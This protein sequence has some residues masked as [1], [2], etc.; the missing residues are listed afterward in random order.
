LI[1]LGF[2]LIVNQFVF[3][4]A[5][6]QDGQQSRNVARPNL[7]GWHLTGGREFLYFELV[8][9]GL[10]LLLVRNLRS[11]ALGRILGAMRDSE[12]GAVSVGVNLRRYKLLVFGAAAFIAAIGGALLAMQQG[13]VNFA[14]DGPYSPLSGLYWF[15]AVVVFGLSY[16]YSAI[17]A[18]ILFVAVDVLTGK[19]QSSLVAIGFIAL[20]IGYLPGGLIG[21]VLRFFRGDGIDDVSPAQRSLA[22]YAMA[23]Q[24]EAD[25]PPP[26]TGLEPTAYAEDLLAGRQ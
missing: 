22:E 9:L 25:A 21:T 15:G 13:T 7:F 6:W 10:V 5:N 12:R 26:G 14:E 17:L 20:F 11:G 19:D 23:R 8:I 4:G 1:T 16:R 24:R 2:G 3:Q 18:S